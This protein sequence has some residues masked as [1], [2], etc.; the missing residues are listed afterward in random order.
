MT[1]K[2]FFGKKT[3]ISVKGKIKIVNT[4]ILHKIFYRLECINI[5]R[6]CRV[7]IERKIR[8]LIWEDRRICRVDFNALTLSYEQ[9][10]LKLLDIGTRCE[11]MRIKWIIFLAKSD[12]NNTIERFVADKLVG[13]YRG[14]EGLKILNHDISLNQF[15]NMDPFYL[16]SIKIWRKA[17]INFE[18]A[19]VRTIRNE[20]IYKNCLLSDN[21]NSTFPFFSIG[22]NQSALPMHFKDLPVTHRTS[23]LSS[24][25]RDKIGRMNRAFWNLQNSGGTIRLGVFTENSYSYKI[26]NNIL[27]LEDISFKDLYQNLIQVKE[28]A[29]P[30]E[31]K[32]NTLLRYYTLDMNQEGWKRIW[33]SIHSNLI[34]YEIQSTIWSILHLNYYCGYKEKLLN[35]GDGICKLCGEIEEGVQHIAINCKVLERCL[36]YFLALLRRLNGTDICK[37]EIAFGLA[38]A[39]IDNLTPKDNLRNFLTFTIRTV[40][41]KNRHIDFGGV[42]NATV[43]LVNKS[44]YKIK[45]IL[46]DYWLFYKNKGTIDQFHDKYLIENVIGSVENG[47][48]FL[49][50]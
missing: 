10:G 21:E 41:F 11:A 46:H 1:K 45:Q 32:W 26:D 16:N 30:W 19:S 2:Y 13:S 23:L 8:G 20:I 6:G 25:N 9:G 34:P 38:G 35:Y 50:I 43:A 36:N 29:R 12:P 18:A 37:D 39:N 33:D 22:N 5:S 4:F 15:R 28:I 47:I 24:S 14:I 48:L 17:G 27:K 44:K 31:E 40:V 7:N 3:G 49:I 42:G